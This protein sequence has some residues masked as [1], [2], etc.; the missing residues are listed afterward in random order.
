M[1]SYAKENNSVS[2]LKMQH[3]LKLVYTTGLL[4]LTVDWFQC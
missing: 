2:M 3:F 1:Q 4:P